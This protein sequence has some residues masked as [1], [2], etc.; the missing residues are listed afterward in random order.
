MDR[1]L[2]TNRFR[3]LFRYIFDDID[4]FNLGKD[5]VSGSFQLFSKRYENNAF[6]FSWRRM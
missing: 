5:L 2:E 6:P 3:S 4:F 1:R